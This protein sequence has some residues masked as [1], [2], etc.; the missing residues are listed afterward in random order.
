[1]IV[2]FRVDASFHIGTGHLVRCVNL[3]ES[4]KARGAKIIFLC[5]AL[6]KP[7]RYLLTEKK[8]EL[9]ELEHTKIKPI[10]S[11]SG[12]SLVPHADWLATS[13]AI[14]A[15]CCLQALDKKKL[16]W[17][18]VDHYALDADWEERMRERAKYILVIDDLADRDHY[19]DVLLDQNY[20]PRRY[21]DYL[22]RTPI[23][24]ELLLGP[25]Y[26]LV[27]EEFRLWRERIGIR[28][29]GTRRVLLF[30]GGVDA[31]NFTSRLINSLPAEAFKRFTF[32]I[33]IGAMHSSLAEV[34]SLCDSM[35]LQLHI[36]TD[37]M[38]ELMSISDI[39]VGAGGSTS[40]ER[41]CVGLP[42]ITVSLADNQADIS[43]ALSSLGASIYLGKSN[44]I[45]PR[46]VADQLMSLA[47]RDWI[48]KSMSEC[49]FKIVDGEGTN[50]VCKVMG[51]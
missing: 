8:F 1:M 17:L 12:E 31:P 50:R 20:S 13:Q 30:F 47:D 33:V 23:S 41:C 6:P 37:R 34:R 51:R 7:L 21:R 15:E 49:A 10:N 4:L 38:A 44:S 45:D 9:L 16:D 2:G 22:T 18:I 26:S 42:A 3:A 40:W 48:L 27:R 24:S 19:C 35:K 32:N 36:Q 14:D 43:A 11:D 39:A 5:R 25:Q 29:F 46:R 28:S